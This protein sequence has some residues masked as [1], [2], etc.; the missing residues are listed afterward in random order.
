LGVRRVLGLRHDQAALDQLDRLVLVENA[1]LDQPAVFSPSPASRLE[2]RGIAIHGV[3]VRRGL[4]PRQRH[5]SDT[6]RSVRERW[7][8]KKHPF[9]QAFGEGTLPL[10][11]MGVYKAMHWHFV[12]RAI[13]SFGVLFACTYAAPKLADTFTEQLPH[14]IFME[15]R[16]RVFC[17]LTAVASADYRRLWGAHLSP[18]GLS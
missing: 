14:E 3:T 4:T 10:R 9:F 18:G 7:H 5:R 6:P 13:A 2:P 12:Q 16:Q 17:W 8:T 1:R 15:H 11:A